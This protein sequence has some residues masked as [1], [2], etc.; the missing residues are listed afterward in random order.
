MKCL[1]GSYCSGYA[2]SPE[3]ML[4]CLRHP[5]HVW[6]GYLY[7]VSKSHERMFTKTKDGHHEKF[8]KLFEKATLPS[9]ETIDL[10][11]Y[12]FDKSAHVVCIGD[13]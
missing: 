5:L 2:M 9:P 6:Y 13:I 8:E 3:C 4:H 11:D 1:V 12:F 7:F 10:S